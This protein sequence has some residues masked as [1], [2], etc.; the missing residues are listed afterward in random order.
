MCANP[1]LAEQADSRRGNP[2]VADLVARARAGDRQA[3]DALVD[4]YVPLIWAICRSHRLGDADS[5][6]VS[7]GVWLHLVEQLDRIRD[8]AALAGWL[9]TTARRECIRI[10]RARGP[11]P[12]GHVLDA[13]NMPDHRALAVEQELLRAERDGALREALTRLPACCRQLIALLCA[14]PPVSYAEISA[15]LGIAAG[16]IGPTR[17]RCLDKLRRDPAIAA[18]LDTDA[19]LRDA[20]IHGRA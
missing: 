6:D 17:S 3:W 2:V 5:E 12:A 14:D 20:E 18:L 4:R 8:P 13:G 16:S 19:D 7:Q 15:R 11:Q 9:A 1:N 10:L